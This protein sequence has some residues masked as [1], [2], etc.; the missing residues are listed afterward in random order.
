MRR[1]A[2][3]VAAAALAL[4]AGCGS[5]ARPGA[6]APVTPSAVDSPT[7]AASSA[8]VRTPAPVRK[9]SARPV[10]KPSPRP[11]M[12]SSPTRRA[13]PPPGSPVDHL[14]GVGNATQV[15]SVIASG[16]GTS[17][18]TVTA[19]RKS[20]TEWRVALGPWSAR[21]GRNG[22]APPGAKREGDG[23]T[24]TG[25][26]GFSFF[27]G[28]DP[29]P[30]GIRYSWRHASTYDVWDD[31]SS[32]PRYNEWVDTRTADAGADPEPM[33]QVP[34]YDAAAVIAYNTSRTPG[35]GSAIFF[36]VSHGSATAGCVS[37]AYGD[38][39]A[40]LRWLDPRYSP[41]IIMGAR[42]AVTR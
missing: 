11:A 18:A 12:S 37:V 8:P 38:V 13:A 16:Y 25:S 32:S 2:A 23:R 28:V 30:S 10:P 26:Y 9:R 6:S 14:V 39:V 34:S 33:H 20:S 42:S 36:H 19:Y 22:F 24:P 7:S 29:S 1:T 40:L 31:D 35:L 41:R 5:T 17:Y 3:V 21:I 4:P 15:V 27:F